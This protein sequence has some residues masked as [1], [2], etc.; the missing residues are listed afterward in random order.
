M[1]RNEHGNF[2][3]IDGDCDINFICVQICIHDMNS[4]SNYYFCDLSEN[5]MKAIFG[6][7]III[8]LRNRFFC[9]CDFSFDF[10]ISLRLEA[11]N[12]KHRVENLL[13]TLGAEQT[14]LVNFISDVEMREKEYHLEL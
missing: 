9:C 2:E 6:H 3:S 7:T 1:I 13:K 10:F 5:D 12:A 14:V 11:I 8:F 4:L